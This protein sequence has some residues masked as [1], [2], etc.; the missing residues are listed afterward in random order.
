M[1]HRFIAKK[2]WEDKSTAMGKSDEMAKSFD[3]VIDLS[4]GDPD[5]TTPD[6]IIEAAFGDARAGHTKYTDF[7]GDPELRKELC[8]FYMEDYG[9]DVDDREVF[10]CASGCLAMYLVLEA[11]LDEGDEVILQ[12]PYFT[13]YP[14][15]V[16]LAGGVPVDLPTYEEEDFQISIERLESLVTEKTKAIIINSPSNPTGNCLD[17]ETIEKL[18]AFCQEKDLIVISDEI[19]TAFSF[20]HEFIPFISLPGMKE[21]TITINSFSKNFVMTGWRI[22]NIIAPDFIVEIIQQINE[23]VVFTAPSMSQRGAIYAL[24]NRQRLQQPISEEFRKRMD[25]AAKRIN[26][27]PGMHVIYPPK[28]SF[29][30]FP[31]IRDFRIDGRQATSQ[32]V[33]DYILEKAHVLTLP[34]DAFGKCGEG[35]IRMC[36]TVSMKKLEE[37][38]D[39]IERIVNK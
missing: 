10:V 27:I 32:Q 33:A 39:R 28:G 2:Y 13:P 24:R 3:D 34:G 14:Q 22:G 19:Y 18:A 7:R 25:Y 12:A 9:I 4:L 6:E 26:S 11:V 1:K 38:F 16:E 20:Q 21:R 23:N 35:H 8:S 5:M 36:C 37:A 31:S 17:I 30:L 15:Q 29:Y